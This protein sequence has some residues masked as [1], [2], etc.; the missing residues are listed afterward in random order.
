MIFL[1]ER[2]GKSV[3]DLLYV[4]S[5]RLDIYIEKLKVKAKM[6]DMELMAK[7]LLDLR[8]LCDVGKIGNVQDCENLDAKNGVE[9]ILRGHIPLVTLL[10]N[11]TSWLLQ[12]REAS[13]MALI[14]FHSI[15]R[16]TIT[17]VRRLEVTTNTIPSFLLL[18]QHS[19]RSVKYCNQRRHWMVLSWK[20]CWKRDSMT[21][22][23]QQV[24]HIHLDSNLV[25]VRQN[26]FRMRGVVIHHLRNRPR[27]LQYA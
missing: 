5:D 19:Y 2:H 12:I 16:M 9:E 24:H 18:P 15:P 4:N 22:H 25:M 14:H 17:G 8:F 7:N 11:V 6:Q 27:L 26:S 1:G 20:L 23:H 21:D 10:G 13:M 3:L